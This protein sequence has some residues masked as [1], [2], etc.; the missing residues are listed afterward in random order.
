MGEVDSLSLPP[1]TIEEM[2]GRLDKVSNI[3]E[4]VRVEGDAHYEKVFSSFSLF[5][6]AYISRRWWRLHEQLGKTRLH[7]RPNSRPS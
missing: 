4:V 7:C 1:T 6:V 5:A 2:Q 3:K